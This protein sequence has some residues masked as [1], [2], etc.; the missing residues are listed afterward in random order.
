MTLPPVLGVKVSS[1]G[2]LSATKVAP[3]VLL[4]VMTM[5]TCDVVAVACSVTG[6]VFFGLPAFEEARSGPTRLRLRG[7]AAVRGIAFR[8]KTPLP[9]LR[10]SFLSA[11][12]V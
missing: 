12:T 4:P 8:A 6:F 10:K 2:P 1:T 11:S 5:P 3:R 7:V 9:I